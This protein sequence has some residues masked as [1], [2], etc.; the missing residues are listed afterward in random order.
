MALSRSFRRAV[1]FAAL[2]AVLPARGFAAEEESGAAK[3]S[4]SSAKEQRKKAKQF[5]AKYHAPRLSLERRAAAL[6]QAVEIG[7]EGAAVAKEVVAKDL[8]QAKSQFGVRPNTSALDEQI[9]SLRKTLAELRADPKLSH[10]QTE[11]IGLP[12]LNQLTVV[13]G[14]QQGQ[15][16]PYKKK[17]ATAAARLRQ[18][19]D[20]FRLLQK[21]WK[22]DPPLPLDEYLA[23]V[24]K[25]IAAATTP[26]EEAIRKV[27][28][29]NE[30]IAPDLSRDLVEGMDAVNAI[31]VMCG[32]N[33]LV[34]DPKLC[35]AARGH[36][37]DMQRLNFFAHE[38]PVPGKESFSDRAKLAGTTAS[39][40]NIYKGSSSPRDAIKAWFLSPGHHK[41]MLGEGHTRQ[42][43]GRVGVYWTQEFGA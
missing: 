15:L 10:A 9:E 17:A 33:A 1:L 29:E 42:G 2:L 4:E 7:P 35:E 23:G 39:G 38:S 3:P 24:E 26:T 25:T 21:E 8:K 6:K 18:F 5:L 31:R 11:K 22:Q 41:N 34:Y 40:E 32:L 37:G 36:S 27:A 20:I 12:A 30:K 16:A 43:L 28:E 14:Q 13:Y 19:A